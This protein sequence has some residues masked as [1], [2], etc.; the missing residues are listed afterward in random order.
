MQAAAH[1][2][3]VHTI[4]ERP[5][6]PLHLTHGLLVRPRRQAD[7]DVA[8][9]DEDVAAVDRGRRLNR[10]QRAVRGERLRN[11]RR[12]DAARRR[13]GAHDQRE[14]VEHDGNV[15]DED[16]VGH[17][18]AR[19]EMLDDAAGVDERL[20]VR[21]M[22]IARAR[23]VDRRALDVRQLARAKGRADGAGDRDEH[24]LMIPAGPTVR[25]A[26]PSSVG[27]RTVALDSTNSFVDTRPRRLSPSGARHVPDTCQARA[28][29]RTRTVDAGE[30]LRTNS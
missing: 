28:W 27:G 4:A 25:A 2:R 20:L 30:C 26:R 15:L 13:A 17:L 22:L 12:L 10:C 6:D 7:E 29:H 21:V 16:R 1:V 5:E 18:R 19:V 24:A 8:S 11:R 14:L 9:D 3:R 23:E